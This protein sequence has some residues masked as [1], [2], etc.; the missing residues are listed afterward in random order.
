MSAQI[1]VS[2]VTAVTDTATR[3]YDVEKLIASIRTSGKLQRQVE[4]LRQTYRRELA[5]HGDPKRA[6]LAAGE[7]KKQLPAVLWSGTFTERK[8]DALVKHSG[9]ICAD[10][11]SLNGNLADVR[12]KLSE[13]PYL[14]ALFTSP[15][16]DGLKAVFRVYPDTARH[17]G[18]C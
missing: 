9:L 5:Q 16:G 2:T 7:L 6:K 18:S 12:G 1:Q 10:L 3:D 13:S 11:D 4:E 14:W 17:A 8:N 15:S